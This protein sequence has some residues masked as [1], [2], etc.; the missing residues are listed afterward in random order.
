MLITI[1]THSG[2]PIYRQVQDQ[3]RAQIL[4]KALSPDTRIPSVRDLAAQI[5]VNPMTVSKAYSLLESEGLLDRRRGVGLFVR[6]LAQHKRALD[7][8]SLLEGLLKDAAA[9]AVQLGIEKNEAAR[10][11]NELYEQF[12]GKRR[13]LS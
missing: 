8:A 6:P 2:V 4:T 7:A 9:S 13:D 11:F 12:D 10:M 3:I 1:D 5:K